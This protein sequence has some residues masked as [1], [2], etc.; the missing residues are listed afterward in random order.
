MFGSKSKSTKESRSSGL[1]SEIQ[2]A[3]F[4]STLTS[5]PE[6]PTSAT[7]SKKD[8]STGPSEGLSYEALLQN[9][10]LLKCQAETQEAQMKAAMEGLRL[11]PCHMYPCK[12]YHNDV[13]WVC[14]H[15]YCPD[16]VGC[17]DSPHE[18]QVAFDKVWMGDPD[19]SMD[20]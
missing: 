20:G 15:A 2:L 1:A 14:E 17:G 12:V 19:A 3:S 4:L 9:A 13:T 7:A 16:A 10:I 18:A 5:D 8:S 6:S 11:R